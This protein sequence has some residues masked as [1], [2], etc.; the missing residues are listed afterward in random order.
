MRACASFE[1]RPSFAGRS[2]DFLVGQDTSSKWLIRIDCKKHHGVAIRK[3]FF[4]SS[5]AESYMQAGEPPATK[6]APDNKAAQKIFMSQRQLCP[7][8]TSSVG[9][10]SVSYKPS[11][12]LA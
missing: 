1:Q 3:C 8:L 9:H 7:P 11:Y 6:I 10:S 12:Q 4:R 2:E 5:A